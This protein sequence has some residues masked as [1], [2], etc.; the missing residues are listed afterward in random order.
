VI[1]SCNES[2]ECNVRWC[3]CNMQ[4][5]RGW[6]E[7]NLLEQMIAWAS[8][9][10]TREGC[11]SLAASGAQCVMSTFHVAT[12]CSSVSPAQSE[13]AKLNLQ[14]HVYTFHFTKCLYSESLAF[15]N[16]CI[17]RNSKTSRHCICLQLQL[18]GAKHRLCWVRHLQQVTSRLSVGNQTQVFSSTAVRVEVDTTWFPKRKNWTPWPE[19]ASELY[20]PSDRRLSAKSVSTFMDRGCHVVS[21]TD[22]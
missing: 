16:L 14:K 13:C 10:P 18:T 2:F 22:P 8:K 1:A 7:P 3:E 20:R 15:W 12:G 11:V 21:V 4:I 5:F 6:R 9:Q 17:A 19:S